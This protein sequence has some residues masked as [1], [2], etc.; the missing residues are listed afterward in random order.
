MKFGQYYSL[1]DSCFFFLVPRGQEAKFSGL[2]SFSTNVL[3][4]LPLLM[5]TVLYSAFG[6]LSMGLFVMALFILFGGVVIASVNMQRGREDAI[7]H[8]VGP[9]QETSLEG[10]EDLQRI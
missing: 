7:R 9:T 4:W 3:A 10:S 6:S 5:F 2:F 1:K 8:S